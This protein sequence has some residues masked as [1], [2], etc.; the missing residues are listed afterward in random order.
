MWWICFTTTSLI[1]FESGTDKA[2]GVRI[3][4]VVGES[5]GRMYHRSCWTPRAPAC[6]DN[7][8]VIQRQRT[9]L[10][11]SEADNRT[12]VAIANF[13]PVLAPSAATV[14][15]RLHTASRWRALMVAAAGPKRRTTLDEI[16]LGPRGSP[17]CL[18]FTVS[19]YVKA[20]IQHE[21]AVVPLC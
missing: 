1:S 19:L 9:H 13:T 21:A 10:T 5:I 3:R 4:G 20:G 18:I 16:A 6:L 11:T 8:S 12:S 14:P 2:E 15:L 7:H 17:P